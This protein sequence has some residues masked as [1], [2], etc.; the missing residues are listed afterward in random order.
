[1]PGHGCEI[2]R[3]APIGCTPASPP[4][5]FDGLQRQSH[6]YVQLWHQQEIVDCSG[7]HWESIN[8]AAGEKW[9]PCCGA[10]E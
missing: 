5:E 6:L 3:L 10:D 2:S 7:S 4:A 9:G 8:S 1:M